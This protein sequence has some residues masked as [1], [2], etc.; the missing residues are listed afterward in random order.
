MYS[1]TLSALLFSTLALGSPFA[2]VSPR[3]VAPSNFS[4]TVTDFTAFQADPL[5]EGAQSNLSFHVA[6]TRP[7]LEKEADCVIPNT[8]FWLYA[9]TALYEYCP[10]Q[11]PERPQGFSF[12]FQEGLVAVRRA[13]TQDGKSYSGV[14]F[15]NPYWTEGVNQTTTPTGKWLYRKE[16][17]MFKVGAM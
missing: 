14:A 4:F 5:V 8:Y 17:W 10:S 9:I 12:M 1:A 3:Q 6:D 7:G 13:W 2:A 16:P 15:V 11:G